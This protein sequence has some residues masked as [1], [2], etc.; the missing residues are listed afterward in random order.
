MARITKEILEQ[1]KSRRGGWSNIQIA[2]LGVKSVKTKRFNK[3]WKR[4]LIG[5]DVPE[6]NIKKFLEM[7]NAHL[8]KGISQET[9]FEIQRQK[10]ASRRAEDET[11]VVGS[12]KFNCVSC[13]HRKTKNCDGLSKLSKVCE[14]WYD[15]N[16]EIIGIAY[17]RK[18]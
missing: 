6:E 15:P 17:E 16:S 3:G 18:T 14:Y 4:K 10:A 2:A 8:K 11:N 13:F 5:V 1:G 9:L 7:K 12:T